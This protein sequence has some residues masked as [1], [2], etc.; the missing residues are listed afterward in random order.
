MQNKNWQ[1]IFFEDRHVFTRFACH[2]YHY[3]SFVKNRN[4]HFDAKADSMCEYGNESRDQY[5]LT[6]CTVKK[7]SLQ[8]AA[9]FVKKWYFFVFCFDNA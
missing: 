1:R 4:F 5:H 7:V 8:E 6:Q 2:G 3:I 9:H